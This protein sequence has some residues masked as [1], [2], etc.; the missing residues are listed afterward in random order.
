MVSWW[1]GTGM[2]WYHGAG[3]TSLLCC[4][5]LQATFD[6]S[7]TSSTAT[8]FLLWYTMSLLTHNRFGYSVPPSI[9]GMLL[10][11]CSRVNGYLQ[12]PGF[13]VWSPHPSPCFT[14]LC[15]SKMYMSGL[16]WYLELECCIW[17]SA[18]LPFTC[19]LKSCSCTFCV[20]C[21]WDFAARKSCMLGLLL[22]M[23]ILSRHVRTVAISYTSV[24]AVTQ[25]SF[26][27]LFPKMEHIW[28]QPFPFLFSPLSFCLGIVLLLCA[29]SAVQHV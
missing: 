12:E 19:G 2:S 9:Q 16:P 14:L 17:R 6:G 22:R 24:M 4:N 13:F 10:W 25:P 21:A 15:S 29:L 26:V 27:L 11:W 23:D 7:F 20:W 8:S 1:I 18:P 5:I 3:V 28:M